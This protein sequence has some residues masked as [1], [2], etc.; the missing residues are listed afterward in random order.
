M[1]SRRALVG[2][3]FLLL[4]ACSSTP[5]VARPGEARLPSAP[6]R[7]LFR[8][9]DPAE[10]SEIVLYSMGLL[11]V[12][13][14]F[15]GRNPESGLDCSGMVSYVIEQ[16]SGKKLPHNAA[17]IADL[18]RPVSREALQPADLVF[19]NTSGPP[20][21]HMGIYLGEGRF[22]HAPSG[23]GFVRLDRLDS[24]YFSKRFTAARSLF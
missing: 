24:P 2:V 20:Y 6:P 9:D 21:S 23:S 4:A 1:I 17:K 14:R 7:T 16:V 8:L 13:Y 19:F 18:T 12:G 3:P 22:V 5:Q 11:E 10:A 15:G